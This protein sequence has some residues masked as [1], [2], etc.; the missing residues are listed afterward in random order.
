MNLLD[1]THSERLERLAR[2]LEGNDC[3]SILFVCLGNICRSPAADALMRAKL[4]A[5]G[6]RRIG[7]VDSAGI[8]GWHVG[9]LPDR[10]MR[11]HGRRRGLEI[12]HVC[13]QISRSDF[14][15]FDII[16]G[17]DARNMR[18]LRSMAATIEEEEKV[19]AMAEFFTPGSVFDCV[20]DPYYGGA[21]GFE[22][23]LDL[24]DEATG[25][26]ADTLG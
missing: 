4:K 3:I 11:V 20:P 2:R 21:E 16:I 5:G 8:G 13:R 6:A 19:Y 17:M 7:C 18:D 22:N 23:V 24:L 14:D 9:D 10:R 12:D 26:I 1:H 25:N 15:R